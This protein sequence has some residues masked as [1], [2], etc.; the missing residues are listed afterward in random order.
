MEDKLREALEVREVVLFGQ[1]RF[2]IAALIELREEFAERHRDN[3]I[4]SLSRYIE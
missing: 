2:E 4:Q 3:L 1:G